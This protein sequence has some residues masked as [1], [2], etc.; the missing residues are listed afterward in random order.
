[1][2]TT[3]ELQ[4]RIHK[5]GIP[6]R[7]LDIVND[8]FLVGRLPGCDLYLPFSEVSRHHCRLMRLGA[9]EW[10]VEDLGSTNGTLL[11]QFRLK[12]VQRI[13]HG[14]VIQIGNIFIF[15]YLLNSTSTL[16][17][18]SVDASSGP[19]TS[20]DDQVRTILRSAEELQQQWIEGDA[21]KD[22]FST[23]HIANA[24][25]KYV[26]EIAKTLSSAESID[27]I[28]DRVRDVIFQEM[29]GIER[30]ALLIDVKGTGNL[31]LFKAAGRQQGYSGIR[32]LNTAVSNGKKKQLVALTPSELH[33]LNSGD[34]ISRSICQ[35][36]FTE[37]VALKT[38]D[39]QTD[40]RF[41]GEHSILSKGI[42]GALAVPLWD[43]KQIVG[44][45]YADAQLGLSKLDPSEDQDLSFFSTIAN[46][47]ASSV[48][49]WLLTRKLQNEEQIRQRLERYHSPAV[50]QQLISLGASENFTPVE[51]DVSVLFADL[52]GFTSLS[53]RLSPEEIA[54]LLN[55]FFEEMLDPLFSTGGTLDKFIGDCIMAFFGAPEPQPDHADRAVAAAWGMLK[56][57]E[58]MN[59][60]QVWPQPL[61]L[62]I[63]INSGKSVVGDVGSSQR[64]DYTVL[65]ATVNLASRL[66]AVCMPGECV[67]GEDTYRRLQRHHDE[68]APAGEC[69]FKGI[70]RAIQVYR[71]S[72]R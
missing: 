59:A 36:V 49:R 69:T 61:E 42:S 45:L 22:P 9:G 3:A 26:V 40:E 62:R 39:A 63:A 52:V 55:D 12:S 54:R 5:E 58:A 67:I 68:F 41:E 71:S 43:E 10:L 21:K 64:A 35:Q 34:W 23:E 18:M 31:E 27:A 11:N 14:D 30:L 53:E 17:Q 24:R 38:I 48:Q 28:F 8:E 51:A 72:W 20:P 44:V 33:S 29:K 4:L 56:R 16:P 1:M 6:E 60:R 66:E 47:V 15:I 37:K 32:T 13:N 46:L 65:G 57:L 7:M 19:T 50:V 25:L 2:N 70:D